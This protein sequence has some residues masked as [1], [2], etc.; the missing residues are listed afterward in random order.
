[1]CTLRSPHT[2]RSHRSS[3][4]PLRRGTKRETHF[5]T[6]QTLNRQWT[7][8]DFP[9]GTPL[10]LGM[11]RNT[12]KTCQKSQHKHTNTHTRTQQQQQSEKVW[13]MLDDPG[14]ITMRRSKHNLH[15]RCVLLL[16]TDFHRLATL[17]GRCGQHVRQTGACSTHLFRKNTFHSKMFKLAPC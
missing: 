9:L 6:Q 15:S 2:L 13:N 11:Y 3:F 10:S 1:M 17:S 8:V 7:C 14:T 12:S 5:P 16:A 4:M